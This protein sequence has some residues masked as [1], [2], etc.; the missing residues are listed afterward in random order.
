MSGLR[1]AAVALYGVSAADRAAV[2]GQLP[3]ADRDRL[4]ALLAELQSLGF[5]RDV[6][7]AAGEDTG[8]GAEDRLALAGDAE[9]FAV[10][11]DEPDGLTARLLAV[12][13]WP[14]RDSLLEQFPPARRAAILA[15]H[16]TPAPALQDALLIGLAARVPHRAASIGGWRGASR[17]MQQWWR[18]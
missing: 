9:L 13:A 11:V 3:P 14:W 1:R 18:Q 12:R 8:E 10:L 5:S 6:A 4:T 7:A 17:R 15:L 16:P 2:L